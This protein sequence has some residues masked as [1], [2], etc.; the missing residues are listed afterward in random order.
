MPDHSDNKVTGGNQS[1]FLEKLEILYRRC[2]IWTA[3]WKLVI[4]FPS[5]KMALNQRQFYASVDIFVCHTWDMPG[6]LQNLLQCTNCSHS[7]EFSSVQLLSC[8][9]LFVTPWTT[10]CQASLSK[11]QSLPKQ[12]RVIW[13]QMS[14]DMR[15]RNSEVKLLRK[16]IPEQGEHKARGH[17]QFRMMEIVD[18]GKIS[19]R[20]MTIFWSLKVRLWT[21]FL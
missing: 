16:N 14:L 9:R 10:A 18:A 3:W 2:D 15:L 4:S 5:R 8:V 1:I 20:H 7:K 11:S 19:W 21:L 17:D 13:S 12:Q 6:M